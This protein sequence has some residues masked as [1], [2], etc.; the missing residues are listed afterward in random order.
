MVH[1]DTSQTVGVWYR[2]ILQKGYITVIRRGWSKVFLAE[3]RLRYTEKRFPCPFSRFFLFFIFK[4]SFV[5]AMSSHALYGCV[6]P[7]RNVNSS[8]ISQN[9]SMY[10]FGPLDLWASPQKDSSM[11]PVAAHSTPKIPEVLVHH[12]HYIYLADAENKTTYSGS[13]KAASLHRYRKTSKHTHH[14]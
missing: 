1:L 7:I 5:V 14:T 8:G 3:R 4:F 9:Y 10:S 11:S 6:C 13:Y 2:S 12:M